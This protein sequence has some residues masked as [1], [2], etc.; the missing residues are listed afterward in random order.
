MT[1]TGYSNNIFQYSNRSYTCAVTLYNSSND[2]RVVCDS[3]AIEEIS[4]ESKLNDLVLSG[5]IIYTDKYGNVDKLMTQQY[6]YCELLFAINNNKTDGSL[7][8]VGI[9]DKNCFTHQFIVNNINVIDRELNVVK[10]RIDIVSSNWFKCASNVQ[11]SNYDKMPESIFDIVKQCI[12]TNDLKIHEETFDLVKT[13]VKLNYISQSN[14]NLF[15]CLKYLFH[16]LY[17]TYTQKD[18][19]LK[20]LVYDWF[21][22]TYRLLDLKQKNTAIGSYATLMSFFKTNNEMLIQAEPTNIGSFRKGAAKTDMYTGLFDANIFQYF[23]DTNKIENFP[24]P[25]QSMCNYLNNK[26][27]NGNYEQKY[28]PMLQ[29]SQLKHQAWSSYWNSNFDL[30]D[31]ASRF[32]SENNSIIVN[33]TGE[34]RRQPGTFN[35]IS[36]DRSLTNATTDDKKEIEKFKQK[37]RAFEGLWMVSKVRNIISPAHSSFRQQVV[38]CRNFIPILKSTN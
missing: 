25:S 8:V 23:H 19:S 7:N 34:I 11:F 4:Y 21:N 36:I 31:D 1:G 12:S 17:Y 38:L 5:Y 27:D 6:C 3:L 20:F 2:I 22:D 37:Y 24:I 30:Y 32:L 16:K 35:V 9:D 10:Y 29:Y 13:N 26:L 18:D 15:T 14:D 28:Q 33:I